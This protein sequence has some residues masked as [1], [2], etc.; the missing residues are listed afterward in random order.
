MISKHFV[1]L[2][3]HRKASTRKPSGRRSQVAVLFWPSTFHCGFQVLISGI[4]PF[5][6]KQCKVFSIHFKTSLPVTFTSIA[7]WQVQAGG[8]G[9][10]TFRWA[11]WRDEAKKAVRDGQSLCWTL[12][13]NWSKKSRL[14]LIGKVALK[15][16][17]K[18]TCTT[19]R[20]K[21]TIQLI[22]YQI[23]LIE[24]VTLTA[25]W[26]TDNWAK[27]ARLYNWSKNRHLIKKGTLL[28]LIKKQLT[29]WKTGNWLKKTRLQL[30]EYRQLIEKGTLTTD[31]ISITV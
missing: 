14:Q 1:T 30:I 10:E 28:Q 29:D 9:M 31:Q 16:R 7:C 3:A 6:R 5:V 2:A 18:V 4:F 27:K 19:D 21:K 12:F 13:N 8:I 11:G 25:D 17:G 22:E 23:R 26:N 15:S 20:K 24:K